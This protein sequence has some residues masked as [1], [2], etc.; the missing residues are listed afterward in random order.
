MT[1]ANR[2]L[3]VIGIAAGIGIFSGSINT[4][5][6]VDDVGGIT[7]SVPADAAIVYGSNLKALQQVLESRGWRV[8]RDAEGNLLL[9]PTG[10]QHSTVPTDQII[11]A[12]EINRVQNLLENRGWRVER[13]AQGNTLLFPT[14]GR[15]I[16]TS[17]G[18]VT[19]EA[20]P[21]TDQIIPAMEINRVQNLLESR[22]WRVE[23]DAQGNTLLFPTGG[24]EISTSSGEVIPEVTPSTDQIIPAME[25]NRVQNL[26]ESRGWRVERDAQGNTLLFPTGGGEVSKSSGEVTPE[27]TPSTDQIVTISEID[28]LRGLLESRGWRV[29]R[30]AG[31]NILLFPSNKSPVDPMDYRS[32]LLPPIT[33]GRMELPVDTWHEARLLAKAWLKT[34]SR[35]DLT[36]GKIRK[37][38]WIYVVSIVDRDPPYELVNQLL[39]KSK[40]GQVLV[41]FEDSES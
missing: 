9:F 30:E 31:G 40:D 37:I 22:G 24:R 11:P 41:L 29:E 35:T 36:V 23:R 6:A 3:S 1:R 20:T 17:S 13:D 12:T 8:E 21:P 4:A 34:L 15:E 27:V 14:G 2:W 19:P 33:A 32:R 5:G 25:I 7:A 16:S 28:Q 18:E 26:L 10:S 38:N 39:I